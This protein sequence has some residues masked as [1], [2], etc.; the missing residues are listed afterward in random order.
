VTDPDIADHMK[1]AIARAKRARGEAVRLLDAGFPGPSLVW[2]VRAAEV[3]VRDFVLTPY[4]LEQGMSW[5]RAMRKGS[6]VLG[7]SN[8]KAAFARAEEWYGPFD[9]PLTESGENAWDTW[10]L[11]VRRRGV[12]VHGQPVADVDAAEAA[13]V[14]AFAERMASWFSQRLLVGGKHPMVKEVR[15]LFELL[16]RP[17]VPPEN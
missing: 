2:A 17:A 12:I 1:A 16:P 4:Y 8:W 10:D 3:L 6:K 7:S 15:R 13:E 11:I 14:C 9:E 5:Q